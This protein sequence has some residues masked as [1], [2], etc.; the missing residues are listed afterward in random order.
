[1]RGLRPPRRRVPG[2][3][4]RL[5]PKC[6][7]GGHVAGGGRCAAEDEARWRNLKHKGI[8]SMSERF[9][10]AVD[11]SVVVR[12]VREAFGATDL[13][14]GLLPEHLREWLLLE[15]AAE[16]CQKPELERSVTGG[17]ASVTQIQLS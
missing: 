4:E 13:D 7:H 8:P 15:E 9:T 14:L 5:C 16:V 3:A 2:H 11:R 6:L 1:M 12:E 17:R 10:Y